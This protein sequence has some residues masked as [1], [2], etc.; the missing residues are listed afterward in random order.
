M[1]KKRIAD[2]IIIR[3][4]GGIREVPREPVLT[5]ENHESIHRKSGFEKT[6]DMHSLGIEPEANTKIGPD[7]IIN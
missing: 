6:E 5:S 3:V 2:S 7:K 4:G 1:G